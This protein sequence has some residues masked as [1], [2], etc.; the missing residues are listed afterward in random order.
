[1]ILLKHAFCWE[2]IDVLYFVTNQRADHKELSE[3]LSKKIIEWNNIDQKIV[4]MA[5]STFWS[6]YNEIPNLELL[7]DEFQIEIGE[8]SRSTKLILILNIMGKFEH[9]LS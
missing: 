1:M 7:E 3:D 4:E 6:K 5:N 2:W 8:D 9:N